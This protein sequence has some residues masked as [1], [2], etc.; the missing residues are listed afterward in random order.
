MYERMIE[1]NKMLLDKR[2]IQTKMKQ[3]NKLINKM[4]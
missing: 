1:K 4:N 2:Q 3:I